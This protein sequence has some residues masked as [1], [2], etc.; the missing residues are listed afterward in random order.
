MKN[1][2]LALGLLLVSGTW[3]F[4][5][6]QKNGLNPMSADIT[7]V[8]DESKIDNESA[9]ID[10]IVNIVAYDNFS[11]TR[12]LIDQLPACA[13]V[14]YDTLSTPKIVTVDFGTTPCQSDWDGKFREGVIQISWTGPMKAEGSV[15]T[16]TTQNY[17]VGD[18]ADQL[19]KFDYSKTVTNMGL[20]ENGNLHFAISVPNA[21]ITLFDGGTITWTA[22]R[23]REWTE[24]IATPDPS[25]DVFLITGGS[26]G[27]DH[28]GQPF[29]VEITTPLMKDACAWFVSGV[30]TVTHGSDPAHVIDYGDGTCDD[31]AVV[32]FNGETRTIHLN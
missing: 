7:G 3:I 28:L 22:T 2:K 20:N 26:S 23:D 13:T 29:T 25:D 31:L 4:T 11:G 5:S 17:Y 24:G 9:K 6:C 10:D 12:G 1:V 27:T 16:V 32:K 21:T 14:V 8:T 30:K 19:S 18:V 15:K